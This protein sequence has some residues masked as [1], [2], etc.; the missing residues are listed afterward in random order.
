VLRRVIAVVKKLSSRGLSFRGKIEKFG[1]VKNGNF[2]MALELIS[3]FDPFLAN[4]IAKYGNPGSGQTS[5]LSSTICEEFISLI[6]TKVREIIIAEVKSSKYFSIIVDSTPDISHVD[7][8]ALVLRYVPV[9]KVNA[10]ERFLKFLPNVGHKAKEMYDALVVAFTIYD[11]NFKIVAGNRMI[12]QPICPDV[13]KAYKLY[14]Q[15]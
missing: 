14:L 7:E 11:L 12:M 1:S 8:L 2:M 10:V 5:Y 15:N 3:E 6:G 13:M 4:H 9:D